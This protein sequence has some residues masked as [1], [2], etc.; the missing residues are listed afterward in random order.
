VYEIA[1][2]KCLLEGLDPSGVIVGVHSIEISNDG[3]YIRRTVL[4]HVL[5]NRGKIPIIVTVSSKW[6]QIIPLIEAKFDSRN[7]FD[8]GRRRVSS[9]ENSRFASDGR[10]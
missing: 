6:I 2:A 5:P 3:F 1:K 8:D 7:R 4:G 9:P 10:Y